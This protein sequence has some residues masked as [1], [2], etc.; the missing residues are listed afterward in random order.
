MVI[1]L[2]LMSGFVL[3]LNNTIQYRLFL[4]FFN[5]CFWFCSYVSVIEIS[6][7]T[8][9]TQISKSYSSQMSWTTSALLPTDANSTTT[10]M[11]PFPHFNVHFK[12]SSTAGPSFNIT[13]PVPPSDEYSNRKTNI[14]DI[15]GIKNTTSYNRDSTTSGTLHSRTGI[16]LRSTKAKNTGHSIPSITTRTTTRLSNIKTVNTRTSLL[17]TKTSSKVSS[18]TPEQSTPIFRTVDTFPIQTTVA[19]TSTVEPE[20]CPSTMSWCNEL[21]RIYLPQYLVGVVLISAGYPC[22]SVM[23]YTIYSKILGPKPQ[24]TGLPFSLL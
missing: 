6:S 3:F 23:T 2:L 15:T 22:T 16:S 12:E 18:I 11:P 5:Y 20:G 19:S 10:T 13:I 14:T 24:V 1:C 8:G 9:A 4:Y 21:P 17:N 7:T